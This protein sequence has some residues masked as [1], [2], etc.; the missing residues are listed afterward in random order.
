MKTTSRK[1]CTLLLLSLVS[2]A[3]LIFA[4]SEDNPTEPDLTEPPQIPSV[5]TFLMDFDDFTTSRCTD[6]SPARPHNVTLSQDNWGWAALNVGIWNIII[7]VGLSV[8]A[9]AFVE[10]FAHQ[11]QQQPGGAW[12][13]SYDFTIEE[14]T[15]TAELYGSIDT[16]GTYWEMYISKQE[17]YEDFLWYTG[18]ADL[19]LTEG[20]WT[21]NKDPDDPTPFVGIVWHC[22]V[23]DSTADIKYT[24]IVPGGP[25]NGGYIF[26]GTTTDTLYDAF[27]DIYNK[28]YENHT[29]IEWNLTTKDGQVKDEHHFGDEQW[30]CWD[31]D[32]QDI[33]C[34]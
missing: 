27:Y 18:E 32:L 25:E 33:E 15:Y 20:T 13:W 7:T 31:G 8:P 12:L 30:H 4:C 11:P 14:D 17:L 6:F 23:Q 1:F 19:F 29:D 9:A 5:S 16:D 22:N 24:N 26:Y 2:A 28:G 3:I 10:S 21:L 34:P